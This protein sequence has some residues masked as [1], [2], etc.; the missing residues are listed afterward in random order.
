M[1]SAVEKLNYYKADYPAIQKGLGT[2]EWKQLFEE[3]NTKDSYNLFLNKLSELIKL[4]MPKKQSKSG[5]RPK[6]LWLTKEAG[7]AIQTKQKSYQMLRKYRYY[8]F[9]RYAFTRNECNRIKNSAKT[10]Y[11]HKLAN[12]C[13]QNPKAFLKYVYNPRER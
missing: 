2:I 11:E 3:R 1:E 8:S 10:S 12:E 5:R 7:V 13:K 4:H 9:K 6:P